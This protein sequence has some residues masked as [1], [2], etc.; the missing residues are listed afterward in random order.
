[1]EKAAKSRL[2]VHWKTWVNSAHIEMVP[3]F[4]AW[5]FCWEKH[6]ISLGI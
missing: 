3:F 4:F 6:W 5:D 1:M 2:G